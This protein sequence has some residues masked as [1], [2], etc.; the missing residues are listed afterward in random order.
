MTGEEF[1]AR[2]ERIGEERGLTVRFDPRKGKGSHGRLYLGQRFTTVKDRRK[3][4]A[5][6]LLASMLRQLGLTRGDMR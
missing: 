3:E 4:I 1:M 6:G 5:P 2:V